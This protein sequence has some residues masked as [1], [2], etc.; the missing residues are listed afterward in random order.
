MSNQAEALVALANER[1][2]GHMAAKNLEDDRKE[3]TCGFRD[4]EAAY[5]AK[6]SWKKVKYAGKESYHFALEVWSLDPQVKVKYTVPGIGDAK[7]RRLSM[8]A[9][10]L[11][12]SRTFK[13]EIQG[14]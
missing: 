5:V 4:G 3:V 11:E 7:A 2:Q 1:L 9:L 13:Q 14:D 10:V 12:T 8:P 6:L